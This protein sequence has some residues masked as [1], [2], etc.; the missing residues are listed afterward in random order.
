MPSAGGRPVAG[1]APEALGVAHP[2]LDLTELVHLPPSERAV[3]VA[4]RFPDAFG[5]AACGDGS[6]VL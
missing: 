1:R 5:A 4:R 2:M 6:S 3:A